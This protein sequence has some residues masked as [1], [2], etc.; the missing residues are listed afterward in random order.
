MLEGDWRGCVR[1]EVEFDPNL[2]VADFVGHAGDRGRQAAVLGPGKA[3]QPQTGRLAG[4]EASERHWWQERRHYLQGTGRQN[5]P[6][7]IA[8]AQHGT[9]LQGSHFPESPRDWCPNAALLDLVPQPLERGGCR[10]NV[11]FKLRDLVL[12]P[13]KARQ[14]VALP[15]LLLRL[16]PTD[17]E[18]ECVDRGPALVD[19]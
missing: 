6:E 1:R 8:S 2:T 16:Q 18:V 15:G 3:G 9:A 12:Q 17:G 7:G 14:A 4:V 10:G 19:F 13:F 5:R 11:A